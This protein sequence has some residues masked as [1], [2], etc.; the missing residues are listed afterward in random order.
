MNNKIKELSVQFCEEVYQLHP[1]DKKKWFQGAYYTMQRT[2][3]GGTLKEI[4]LKINGFIFNQINSLKD[5]YPTED[6]YNKWFYDNVNSICEIGQLTFGQGQKI[7]NILLKYFYCY[8]HSEYNLEWNSENMFLKEYFK[9]FHAPVDNIILKQLKLKYDHNKISI[10]KSNSQGARFIIDS[11]PVPWSKLEDINAYKI[12]QCYINDLA[13]CN[14]IIDD[15]L[16]FEM[17]ELWSE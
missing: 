10:I 13:K 4:R 11:T 1:F 14:T 5:I 12:V 2:K 8:Y 17:L 7:I 9:F 3:K 16:G 15:R 6:N